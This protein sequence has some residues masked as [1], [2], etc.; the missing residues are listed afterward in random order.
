MEKIQE[1]HVIWEKFNQC[2]DTH[3]FCQIEDIPSL[4]PLITNLF[5]E[6]SIQL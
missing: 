2:Q 6:K 5:I 4:G 1:K 3:Q